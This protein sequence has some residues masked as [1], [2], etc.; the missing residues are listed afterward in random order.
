M[1]LHAA[2]FG[3]ESRVE[4]AAPPERVWAVVADPTRTPEW[5][6]VCHRVEWLPPSDHAE[7][8]ARFR[9]HNKLRIFT[10]SRECVVDECEPARSFAFHTEIDGEESTRWRYTL[11]PAG[12][13]RTLLTETYRASG[14]PTWV[15]LLRKLGGA[16]QSDKDT[17]T[18][19]STSLERIKQ[20]AE[21]AG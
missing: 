19:I 2:D 21:A 1:T 5:S 16:K 4:I 13:G 14:L 7:V 11:A 9:G 12:E 15:W 8:G 18:N 6:P 10:W 3:D 20:L 17:R